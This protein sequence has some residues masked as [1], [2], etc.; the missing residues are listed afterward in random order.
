MLCY[1]TEDPTKHQQAPLFIGFETIPLQHAHRPRR[2]PFPRA[3]IKHLFST[4]S[5]QRRV[6]MIMI[7]SVMAAETQNLTPSLAPPELRAQIGYI[8]RK[9]LNRV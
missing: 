3:H 5:T 9:R 7:M 1:Q 2:R 8:K 6:D 4:T